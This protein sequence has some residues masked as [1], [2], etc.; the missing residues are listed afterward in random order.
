M[1]PKLNRQSD[2]TVSLSV[3]DFS[4]MSLLKPLGDFIGLTSVWT[5]REKK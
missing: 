2:E 5:D 4:V 1:R 3:N